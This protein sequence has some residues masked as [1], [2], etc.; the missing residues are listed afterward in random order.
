[1]KKTNPKLAEFK[2]IDL[3]NELKYRGVYTDLVY[4]IYDID[5]QL[6]YIN[7]DL[8]DDKKIVLTEQD[9]KKILRN[10][11]DHEYYMEQMNDDLES[12]ILDNY[13]KN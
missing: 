4:T 2:I 11:I 8:D 1:M 3:V 9:R 7:E 10:A 12:Y 5:M 13:T 6:E